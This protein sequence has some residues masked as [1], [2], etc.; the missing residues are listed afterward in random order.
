MLF[1]SACGNLYESVKSTDKITSSQDRIDSSDINNPDKDEEIPG[2]SENDDIIDI[3]IDDAMNESTNLEDFIYEIVDGTATIIKYLGADSVVYIPDTIE[4]CP[5]R[6]IKTGA[7]VKQERARSVTNNQTGGNIYIPDTVTDIEEGAFNLEGNTYIT[8]HEKQPDGWKDSSFSGDATD[9]TKTN[10]NVYFGSDRTDCAIIDGVLYVY[11]RPLNGFFVVDC[12]GHEK[13]IRIPDKI[14]GINVSDIGKDAFRDCTH[15]ENITL[16]KNATRIW[17]YAFANCTSLKEVNFNAKYLSKILMCAF[18]NCSSIEKIIIPDTVYAIGSRAFANCGNVKELYIPAGINS[19]SGAFKNTTVE[20]IYFESDYTDF[21]NLP[22][23]VY[24]TLTQLTTNIEYGKRREIGGITK[25]SDV[26][27]LP[28]ST[29]ITVRGYVTNYCDKGYTLLLVDEKNEHG[30]LVQT[31][32]TWNYEYPQ[33]GEYIE[34]VGRTSNFDEQF[35]ISDIQSITVVGEKKNIE[36]IKVSIKQLNANPEKYMYRYLEIESTVVS[37]ETY[38]TF[39]DGLDFPLFSRASHNPLSVGDTI[40][41]R[42]TVT[43]YGAALEFE[44][45]YGDITFKHTSTPFLESSITEAKENDLLSKV[46]IRG[47]VGNISNNTNYLIISDDGSDAIDL[48]MPFTSYNTHEIKVGD[49]VEIHGVTSKYSGEIQIA[50]PQ[51]VTVIKEDAAEY[52]KV[53]LEEINSNPESYLYKF[54]EFEAVISSVSKKQINLE[55]TEMPLYIA[56]TEDFSVGDKITVR[57]IINLY[58]N[59]L[60]FST[61]ADNIEKN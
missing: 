34:I 14:R 39:L 21:T 13:E 19:L 50:Y 41:I 1:T 48:Y 40:S 28:L 12:I 31:K 11:N 15:L 38:Y 23:A 16:S 49:Y 29:W 17:Y 55:G 35:C 22:K 6:T 5:V 7:F 20:K 53:S 56:N 58:N 54:V 33:F 43:Y 59:N 2:G 18:E 61:T 30:V 9:D 57:A 51:K 8:N 10:G 32:N 46:I 4:N 25:I 44:Y 60:Q 36:P 42:G 24:Q 3:P 45:Q 37:K 47:Y 27:N 52:T 26:N